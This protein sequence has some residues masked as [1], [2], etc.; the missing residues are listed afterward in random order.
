ML[1]YGH[2]DQEL[3]NTSLELIARVDCKRT[4]GLLSKL[5]AVIRKLANALAPVLIKERTEKRLN[6]ALS[7]IAM[8]VSVNHKR[9]S[10]GKCA[11][12]T[13]MGYCAIFDER[14]K[15]GICKGFVQPCGGNYYDRVRGKWTWEVSKKQVKRHLVNE[16]FSSILVD[17][18]LYLSH[19]ILPH[20]QAKT[21]SIG[22]KVC[23]LHKPVPVKEYGRID[24]KNRNRL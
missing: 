5:K 11:T 18:F 20:F 23:A 12:L 14:Y 24:S 13:Q 10:S 3:K 6:V 15:E 22:R 19:Y 4:T 16:P 9:I 2:L 7:P 8:S 1:Q 21:A 17:M